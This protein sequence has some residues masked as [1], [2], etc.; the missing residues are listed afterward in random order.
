MVMLRGN[1]STTIAKFCFA[2]AAGTALRNANKIA[3]SISSSSGLAL[4]PPSLCVNVDYSTETTRVKTHLQ[5]ECSKRHST[6]THSPRHAASEYCRYH[7]AINKGTRAT[8]YQY[9]SA[10]MR[11]ERCGC[12]LYMRCHTALRRVLP[13]KL[14]LLL[15]DLLFDTCIDKGFLSSSACIHHSPLIKHMVLHLNNERIFF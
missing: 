11:G 7:D 1:K 13:V 14:S 10:T 2:G 4:F 5:Y 8:S 12:V 15:R 3:D 6:R 9:Q